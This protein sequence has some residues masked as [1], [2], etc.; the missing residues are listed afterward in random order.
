[1]IKKGEV[2]YPTKD[3]AKKALLS[4]KKIYEQ[5]AKSPVRFWSKIS[6]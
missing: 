1:M 4:D 5:A 2:F 6:Q 3:F